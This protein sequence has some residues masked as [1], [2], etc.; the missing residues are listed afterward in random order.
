[1]KEGNEG[2]TSLALVLEGATDPRAEK[3]SE[4]L[5]DD[6]AVVASTTE[7]RSHR[8][9]S[10]APVVTKNIRMQTEADMNMVLLN[11]QE[12]QMVVAADVI[13]AITVTHPTWPEEVILKLAREKSSIRELPDKLIRLLVNTTCMTKIL[14]KLER[15]AVKEERKTKEGC[16]RRQQGRRN[17]EVSR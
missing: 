13:L 4:P 7:H 9:Q 12:E 2:E 8:K 5:L 10:S 11:I 1:M 14:L 16:G 15:E 3:E 17:Y 6:V